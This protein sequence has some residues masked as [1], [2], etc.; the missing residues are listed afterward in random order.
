MPFNQYIK[1]A[2]MVATEQQPFN[3]QLAGM[4]CTPSRWLIT[5]RAQ[6]LKVRCDSTIQDWFDRS[7]GLPLLESGRLSGNTFYWAVECQ[8]CVF[9]DQFIDAFQVVSKQFVKL[10]VVR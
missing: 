9:A 1:E 4:H 3:Q 5:T 6:P 8:W 2:L 7:A 10:F